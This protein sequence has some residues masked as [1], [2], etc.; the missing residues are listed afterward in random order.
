MLRRVLL[1]FV[2]AVLAPSLLPAQKP[3]RPP[4]QDVLYLWHASTL[5]ETEVTEAK[6][7]RRKDDMAYVVNGAS[8]PAR[9]PMAEPIFVIDSRQIRP[10]QLQ[11]FRMEVKNGHREAILS[12]KRRSNNRPLHLSM[13]RLGDGLYKIEANEFLQNGQYAITPEG[14]NQVFC[15]EVY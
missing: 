12:Q 4:K 9:T 10:E 6:E 13:K 3:P 5:I 8:S 15:F 2:F 7:E 1:C 11:M 14:S